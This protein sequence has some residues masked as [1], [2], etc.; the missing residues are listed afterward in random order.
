MVKKVRKS[1]SEWRTLLTERQYQVCRRSGTEPA[2]SGKYHN[3][4]EK[5]SYH[6]V[7]CALELFSS[8]D[9][10]DSGTGWP[11]FTLPFSKDCVE[12]HR[13]FSHG[14]TR[15][16]VRCAACGSHLGHVFDEA[17]ISKKR[18]CI[19]SLSLNFTGK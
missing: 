7:A 19:N 4:K 14:M 8:E 6:C 17:T 11:S 1:D 5:G 2:F 12:T 3:H 9:K 18:Y 15:T 13:D 10:F 16:E